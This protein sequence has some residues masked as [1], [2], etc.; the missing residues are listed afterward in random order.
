MSCNYGDKDNQTLEEFI[1]SLGDT[2]AGDDM[3][4][5]IECPVCLEIPLPPIY[6]C[7]RG[8][9]VCTECQDRTPN[10]PLCRG[11]YC[12]TRSFVAEGIVEKCTF[13]CKNAEQ[14]CSVVLK[15]SEMVRHLKVCDFRPIY[16]IDCN[17]H[18][19]EI[20]YMDYTNHLINFH[21]I[22]GVHENNGFV[23]YNMDLT[24]R[25]NDGVRYC[26]P[27]YY[28]IDANSNTFLIRM[29]LSSAFVCAWV[30][31]V[32]PKENCQKFQVTI[33]FHVP[34]ECLERNKQR[35]SLSW[36][37]QVNHFREDNYHEIFLYGCGL[38]IPA[39]TVR[40]VGRV[41]ESLSEWMYHVNIAETSKPSNTPAKSPPV[42]SETTTSPPDNQEIA[43]AP[44]PTTTPTMKP[45]I[46][47]QISES[48]P[49]LNIS[50]DVIESE[51]IP[52]C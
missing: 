3:R 49:R 6:L 44:S 26:W 7:E 34:R 15:G 35:F 30:S 4:K 52:A 17:H 13:K 12:K 47:T 27:P 11:Y 51:V 18:E 16:C 25:I 14:G 28:F 8:H 23:L 37:G 21:K 43:E 1:S 41:S 24:R 40:E 46:E 32:G 42:S 19:N 50:E 48:V 5:L 10:C 33:E 9:I 45:D 36:K 29:H 20:G 22:N 2:S 39:E 38:I 31:Y